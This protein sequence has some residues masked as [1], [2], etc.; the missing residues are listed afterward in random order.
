ML[1]EGIFLNRDGR[2]VGKEGTYIFPGNIVHFTTCFILCSRIDH[3]VYKKG[4]YI[5]RG[6]IAKCFSLPRESFS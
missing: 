1:L 4:Q 2:N 6:K 5:P 3:I